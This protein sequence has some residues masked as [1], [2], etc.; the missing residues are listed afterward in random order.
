MKVSESYGTMR[1]QLKER[2]GED[3]TLPVYECAMSSGQVRYTAETAET[4]SHR[5]G[6]LRDIV[7]Y[8]AL[9][10]LKALQRLSV[11]NKE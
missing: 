2:G 1:C 10:W 5:E 3:A 8:H 6:V 9:T 7:T 4:R 11:W